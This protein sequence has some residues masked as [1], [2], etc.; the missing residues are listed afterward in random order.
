[1]AHGWR[2]FGASYR[3]VTA[4]LPCFRGRLELELETERSDNRTRLELRSTGLSG[5]CKNVHG[6]SS[7]GE[8]GPPTHLSQLY[9]LFF[10]TNHCRGADECRNGES[11]GGG[12]ERI[13]CG[14]RSGRGGREA[15]KAT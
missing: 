12:S 11:T 4:K 8:C 6:H 14:G 3:I 7:D 9:I 15:C 13:Y 1:M 5:L 2:L 10:L